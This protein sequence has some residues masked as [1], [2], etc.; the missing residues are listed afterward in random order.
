MLF[1]PAEVSVAEGLAALKSAIS[2]WQ[3]SALPPSHPFFGP[4]SRE[5]WDK[6]H[7]RHC[8]LHFSFLTRK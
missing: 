7:L 2:R 5:D 3:R 6:L 8:E 4:M 1:P